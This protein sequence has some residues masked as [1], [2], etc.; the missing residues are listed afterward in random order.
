MSPYRGMISMSAMQATIVRFVR[1]AY[2]RDIIG[3]TKAPAIPELVAVMER[4]AM[5]TVPILSSVRAKRIAVPDTV[6]M[7]SERRNH[8]IKNITACR[9][10]TAIL[11]VLQRDAHAK[12]R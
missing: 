12:E 5:A 11:M 1:R 10:F 3:Q 7:A 8:A 6:A 9:S 2:R 4:S